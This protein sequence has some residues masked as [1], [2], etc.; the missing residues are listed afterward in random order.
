MEV[1]LSHREVGVKHGLVT[2][3]EDG[4]YYLHVRSQRTK[5]KAELFRSFFPAQISLVGVAA[6]TTSL[7]PRPSPQSLPRLG[8][9]FLQV[10]CAGGHFPPLRLLRLIGSCLVAN[11]EYALFST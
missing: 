1:K 2:F 4:G 6:L 9:R 8:T 10:C 3:T 7:L 11:K 5:F